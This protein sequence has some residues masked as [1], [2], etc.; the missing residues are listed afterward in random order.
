[1]CSMRFQSP[2][3]TYLIS[4]G[5]SPYRVASLFRCF[6]RC[7]SCMTRPGVREMQFAYWTIRPYILLEHLKAGSVDGAESDEVTTLRGRSEYEGPSVSEPAPICICAQGFRQ[8]F[9]MATYPA[10]PKRWPDRQNTFLCGARRATR[11][12]SD[13]ITSA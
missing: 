4:S 7:R 11:H 13:S 6:R 12:L 2:S 8:K 9:M 1:M 5:V 10:D 3:T